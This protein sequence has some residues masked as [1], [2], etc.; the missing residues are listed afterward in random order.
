V[1]FHIF[2]PG[3]IFTS[4]TEVTS[5]QRRGRLVIFL[6][7]ALVGA[8]GASS[9]SDAAPDGPDLGVTMLRMGGDRRAIITP[10]QTVSLSIGVSNMGGNA[11]AHNSVLTVVIPAGMKLKQSRPAPDRTEPGKSGEDLVWS[12]GTVP[13]AAFPHLFELD[14]E[15]AS[16]LKRGA[17]LAGTATVT[18]SDRNL[19][20]GNTRRAFNFLVENAAADLVVQSS[21]DGVPFSV[22]D[23]VDF[24]AGIINLGTV[25][26][27]ACVLK[28]TV[29]AKASFKW[30]DPWPSDN[31]GNV[32]TWRL[33]DIAPA[34]SHSVKVRIVLD[35]I[36]RLAAYGF[37]PRLG[38]LNFKFDASTTTNQFNPANGHLE[39]TRYPEPAGSNVTVSLNVIGAEH[40]AELPIGKDVTYEIM[41]GNFGNALGSKVSLSLTLPDG[42]A[43]VDAQPPATSSSKSDNSGSA[44]FSWN[45]GDLA[46]GQSGIVKS[47]VHVTSVGPHGSLVK[48][49]IS[50]AGKDVPSREKTAY[51]LRYAAK[52]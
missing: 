15:A 5:R 45:L 49:K 37:A 12:L 27:S 51:S 35:S 19:T 32:V 50:A 52:R 3:C 13:A 36:L 48:A 4:R 42:L 1:S 33:G 31:S 11:A 25:S 26:A 9:A 28:M 30:S 6:A 41:Y 40:P 24:A 22:D 21:L 14:L 39:I 2:R 16:D 47:K 20:E 43:L 18:T 17:Q 7:L 46:V 38:N 8:G 10:G 44:I 29:P 23:P 34:K